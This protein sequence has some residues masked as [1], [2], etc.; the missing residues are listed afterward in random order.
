MVWFSRTPEFLKTIGYKSPVG[1]SNGP[2]QYVE[3]I[4]VLIWEFIANDPQALDDCNTCM[5]ADRA[6]RPLWTE[7]FPV[8]KD[9]I[10]GFNGGPAK[11]TLIVDIAGGRGHDIDSFHR[12]FPNAPGRRVLQDLSHV[13]DGAQDLSPTVEKMG[14]DFFKPQP[15]EGKFRYFRAAQ[16]KIAT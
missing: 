6:A 8:Q 14:Y 12:S 7:W 4:K 5:E 1:T 9:L 3:N 15:I 13:L 2:L 10:D 16:R 11:D